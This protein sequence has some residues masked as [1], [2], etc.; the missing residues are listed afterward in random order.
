MQAARGIACDDHLISGGGGVQEPGAGPGRIT[1]RLRSV[2]EVNHRNDSCS[3]MPRKRKGKSH[4]SGR[5]RAESI[6]CCR[7]G[8][9]GAQDRM[10]LSFHILTNQE[11]L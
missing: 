6:R 3:L 5:Q 7:A 1:V 9:G 10:I 11:I 2:G 8:R 4:A